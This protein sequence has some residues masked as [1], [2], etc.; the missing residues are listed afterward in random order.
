MKHTNQWQKDCLKSMIIS[1][2]QKREAAKRAC[3]DAD[4]IERDIAFLKKQI[5]ASEKMGKDGFD[6]ERFMRRE[7]RIFERLFSN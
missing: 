3:D 1:A 6:R 4:R 5:E 2:L 7:K